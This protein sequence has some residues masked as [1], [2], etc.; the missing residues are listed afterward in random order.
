MTGIRKG[1]SSIGHTTTLAGEIAAA[2]S[3]TKGR[4][5]GESVGQAPSRWLAAGLEI[6]FAGSVKVRYQKGNDEEINLTC[7]SYD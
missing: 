2:G 7:G 6:I 5:T 3:S 1:E 4:H